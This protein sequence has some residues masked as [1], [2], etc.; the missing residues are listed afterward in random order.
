M[1]VHK[2]DIKLQKVV[3]NSAFMLHIRQLGYKSWY[4]VFMDISP[5][6]FAEKH[7]LF[8]RMVPPNKGIFAQYIYITMQEKQFL[9]RATGI[10]NGNCG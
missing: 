2:H 7:V 5:A 6:L 1:G 4:P 10:Q 3:E 8:A 9:A